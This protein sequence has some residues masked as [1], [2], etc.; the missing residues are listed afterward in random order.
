M[1][2]EKVLINQDVLKS[3]EEGTWTE[4]KG[5]K[6][7][8]ICII[9]FFTQMV[10]EEN[11]YQVRAGTVTTAITAD[12]AITDAAAEM[13][14]VALAGTTI[15][16]CEVWVT[17]NN[18]GGDSVEVA[19]KSVGA[20]TM[21]GGTAYVPLNLFIGGKVAITKA[22]HAAAGGVTVATELDTT[23][24]QHFHVTNEFAVDSGA[25]RTQIVRLYP[26]RHISGVGA[27]GNPIIWHPAILPILK[28]DACSYVQIASATTAPGYFAHFDF[29]EL[30]T[31][32]VV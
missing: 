15:M 12:E 2:E 13:A 5:T 20:T 28:G 10:I 1:S 32:S 23:T 19:A 7:G 27:Q 30:P 11:A 31:T 21:S 8:E 16:P 22:M 3:D 4:L 9:D 18:D 26:S 24:R 17:R 6:R 14:A 25:E 29:I